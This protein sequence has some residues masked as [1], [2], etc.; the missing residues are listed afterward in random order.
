MGAG[1]TYPNAVPCW[2]DIEQ[3]DTEA[4]QAFYGGLFGWSFED[5][6]PPDAPGSYFV[7]SLDGHVVGGVG[8]PGA[9]PQWNTYVAVDDIA[10]A[11]VDVVRLGGT[12]EE[13]ESAGPAGTSAVC[14]DPEGVELRLWQPGYRQGSE[15]VNAPGSWNFS[16][17][18]TADEAGATSFYGQ[19]F[20]WELDD[21]GFGK[22][23]RRP[24]YGDHLA[25]STDPDI[26]ERQAEVGAPPGFVDCVAWLAPLEVGE[27]PHWH[28]TFAVADRDTAVARALE[29][30]A[31]LGGEPLDTEW[32][33]S[34]VI[35]DPQGA[36]LTLSQ[37]APSTGER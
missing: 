23:W 1:K 11:V 9:T 21:L 7:A 36:V 18:H 17:L 5:T 37:F 2:I 22:M 34:A 16:D 8:M 25:A 30:G 6:M 24:G 15:L 3:P 4:T 27:V 32:T 14:R 33:R 13:P 31:V 10:A 28:V 20:G 29:L 12:A 19:L 35:R 26:H